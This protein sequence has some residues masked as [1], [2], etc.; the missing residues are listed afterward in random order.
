MKKL[1]LI[2][3]LVFSI[4]A[5]AQVSAETQYN[6]R[7]QLFVRIHNTMYQGVSCFYRDAYSY[8]TFYIPP[9]SPSRWFA[10]NGQYTW[11]CQ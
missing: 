2:L 6:N 3:L 7:G 5:Y 4:N 9:R 11:N 8:Y 10:V 1:L